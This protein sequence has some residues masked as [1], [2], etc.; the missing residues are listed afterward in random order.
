MVT[1]T[2]EVEMEIETEPVDGYTTTEH[3]TVRKTFVP[4]ECENWLKAYTVNKPT[5]FF[6]HV[7][8]NDVYS[9]ANKNGWAVDVTD[10]A[11]VYEHSPFNISIE[12]SKMELLNS[13]ME[14]TDNTT[15][16]INMLSSMA[17]SGRDDGNASATMWSLINSTDFDP[18]DIEI[19]DDDYEKFELIQ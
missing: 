15:K 11:T 10:D 8:G 13:I 5:E 14:R 19:P 2:I 4:S 17:S 6:N 18:D 1:I 9:A 3:K 12:A 7:L 16:I